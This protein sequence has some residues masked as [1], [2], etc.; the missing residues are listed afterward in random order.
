MHT[1]SIKIDNNITTV[2]Y[3]IFDIFDKFPYIN[4]L[5]I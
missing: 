3:L 2:Q 1:F 5:H 4:I